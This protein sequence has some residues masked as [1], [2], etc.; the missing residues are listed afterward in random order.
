MRNSVWILL[1]VTLLIAVVYFEYKNSNKI[2]SDSSVHKYKIEQN[3]RLDTYVLEYIKSLSL[4][5]VS[6]KQWG[7]VFNKVKKEENNETKR[8]TVIVKDKTLCIEE[9]CFRLIGLVFDDKKKYQVS[10]FNKNLKNKIKLFRVNET[11][12]ST[13]CIKKIT[14][15]MVSFVDK[16]S[17]RTWKIKLFDINT[18]KYKPK[19]IKE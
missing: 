16:N 14:Q 2:T 4:T 8:L 6:D 5:S 15:R 17:S 12:V 3:K 18:S 11:V 13:V 1:Y 9:K 10:L 19:D 7:I